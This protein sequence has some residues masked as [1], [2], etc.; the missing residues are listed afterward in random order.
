MYHGELH[1]GCLFPYE[2]LVANATN[3]VHLASRAQIKAKERGP[4]FL[5]NCCSSLQSPSY[6]A[7]A[8][9]PKACR[10]DLP[11]RALQ[12]REEV[13]HNAHQASPTAAFP[14]PSDQGLIGSEP[15]C[16]RGFSLLISKRKVLIS[17]KKAAQNTTLEPGGTKTR[18][19]CTM[20]QRMNDFITLYLHYSFLYNSL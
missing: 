9:S 1:S 20:G 15:C 18:A 14:T 7:P 3:N 5:R 13:A 8:A 10:A 11:P 12:R 6:E 2:N 16:W 4:G 19:T 17:L